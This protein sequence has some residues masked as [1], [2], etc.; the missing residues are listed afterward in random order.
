MSI[1]NPDLS[2][3]HKYQLELSVTSSS[4]SSSYDWFKMN[5]ISYIDCVSPSSTGF[6]SFMLLYNLPI[7]ENQKTLYTVE[8]KHLRNHHCYFKLTLSCAAEKKQ[9]FFKSEYDLIDCQ[10]Q[11]YRFALMD[12]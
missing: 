5:Y 10:V 12:R 6:P 4:S 3:R 2:V 1:R 8:G 7:S 9:I 11:R